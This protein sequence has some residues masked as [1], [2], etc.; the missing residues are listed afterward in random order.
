MPPKKIRRTCN[1]ELSSALPGLDDTISRVRPIAEL[2]DC[3]SD[4]KDAI[5]PAVVALVGELLHQVDEELRA[6][7]KKVRA[8][9][10][11]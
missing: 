8:M 3:L 7:R 6:H 4:S 10:L 11:E 1:D 5:P 9:R 2:I